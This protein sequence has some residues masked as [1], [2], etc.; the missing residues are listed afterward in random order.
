MVL[1]LF[2]CHSIY[3]PKQIKWSP[4]LKKGSETIYKLVGKEA[5]KSYPYFTSLF[6]DVPWQKL[7]GCIVP[8]SP[9]K[10]TQTT[11]PLAHDLHWGTSHCFQLAYLHCGDKAPGQEAD[12]WVVRSILFQILN[13]GSKTESL[14]QIR[15]WEV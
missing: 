5:V 7:K 12:P 14:S 4:T 13:T 6:S 15:E 1:C 8:V 10:K 11:L 3:L 2:I 9:W